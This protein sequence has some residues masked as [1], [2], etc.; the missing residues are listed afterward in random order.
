MIQGVKDAATIT[1]GKA[2]TNM[3]ARAIPIQSGSMAV[4]VAKQAAAAVVVGMAAR[5]FLG[6][7]AAR[8]AIAGGLTAPIEGFIKSANVPFVSA[9]LSGDEDFPMIGAW[10]DIGAYPAAAA[11]PSGVGSYPGI[12]SSEIEYAYQSQ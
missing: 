8:F 1:A 7:D 12:E 4:G 9:A 5:Q 6:N 3:V 2:A 10:D 11:L